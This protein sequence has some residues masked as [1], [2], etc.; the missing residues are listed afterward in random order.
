MTFSSGAFL[1]PKNQFLPN[2]Q[3]E[4][5]VGPTLV[6][7]YTSY[8][9]FIIQGFSKKNKNFLKMWKKIYGIENTRSHFDVP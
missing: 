4:R 6:M 1:P 8:S 5:M 2:R 7:L 9:K 3:G